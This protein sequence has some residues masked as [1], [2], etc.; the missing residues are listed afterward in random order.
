MRKECNA[1]ILDVG[2]VIKMNIGNGKIREW[3]VTSV[4]LGSTRQEN[5]IGIEVVDK[6]PGVAGNKTIKEMFVPSNLIE[7]AICNENCIISMPLDMQIRTSWIGDGN[8]EIKCP[9][10]D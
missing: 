1:I 6:L 7:L 10:S 5:L 2:D 3:K 4:C 8:N 9:I